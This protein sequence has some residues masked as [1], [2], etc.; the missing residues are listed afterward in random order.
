MS[1]MVLN[2]EYTLMSLA[3]RAVNFHK[4]EPVWVP[5]ECEKEALKIGAEGVD[6]KMDILDPAKEEA[7][8]ELTND[9]RKALLKEAFI[10]MM[11]E[12]KREDFTAQ[13][14]PATPALATVLGFDVT[15]KERDEAWVEFQQENSDAAAALASAAKN[16]AGAPGVTE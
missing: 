1:Y 4:N 7:P 5:P 14:I 16:E 12:N 15:A 2:R 9:E 6:G 3:G 8:A 11:I 10:D 13:G